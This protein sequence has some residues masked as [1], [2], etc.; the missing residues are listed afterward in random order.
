MIFKNRYDGKKYNSEM[1]IQFLK[2]FFHLSNSGMIFLI[3]RK[4]NMY[5]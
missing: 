3:N 5:S 2:Y 4:V 1:V